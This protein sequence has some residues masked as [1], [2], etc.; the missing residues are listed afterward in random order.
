MAH[1]AWGL[2]WG[3]KESDTTGQLNTDCIKISV[4]SIFTPWS[5]PCCCKILSVHEEIEKDDA[6]CKFE[7][8]DTYVAESLASAV[9]FILFSL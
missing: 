7:S 5:Q 9:R 8:Q 6:P 2:H 4:Y 3:C 1:G